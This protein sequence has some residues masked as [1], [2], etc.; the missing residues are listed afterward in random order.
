MAMTRCDCVHEYQDAKYG[1]GNRVATPMK[2]NKGVRCT[3]CGKTHTAPAKENKKEEKKE[4][5]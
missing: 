1:K 5:K 2:D 4:K 3:V